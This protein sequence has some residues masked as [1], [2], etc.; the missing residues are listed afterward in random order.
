MSKLKRAIVWAEPPTHLH[1]MNNNFISRVQFEKG[2]CELNKGYKQFTVQAVASI[3]DIPP[4]LKVIVLSKNE[5]D[6][7]CEDSKHFPPNF[8]VTV[9]KCKLGI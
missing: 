1:S 4:D 5:L 6:K 8:Q 2:V 3:Q 7:A 9:V